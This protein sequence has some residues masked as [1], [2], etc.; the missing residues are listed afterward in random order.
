MDRRPMVRITLV[1]LGVMLVASAYAFVQLPADAR[2][3]VHWSIDGPPD[4]FV[5]K[6]VGVLLLPVVAAFVALGMYLLPV[7]EPRRANLER[8]GKT[9]AATWVGVLLLLGA[10]HLVA[11]AVAF[12]VTL[13]VARLV[14]I[15]SGLLFIAIGNYLPKVRP[16]Y[17]LGI[18]TPWTLT[19]D[20]A[21]TRTHRLGGKLMLL[22][23][24]ALVVVGLLGV[25]LPAA[26]TVVVAGV[27]VLVAVL[28]VYSYVV[29]REDPAR[30]TG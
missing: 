9:Y 25:G 20:H 24:V 10:I 23:G 1:I 3:P 17:L 29:W 11:I 12:G 19:S 26:G 13:D 21:W 15:G 27:A 5:D 7:I 8:S 18:R 16:N 22:E 2:I 30:H 28:F 6:G 14:L 4:G